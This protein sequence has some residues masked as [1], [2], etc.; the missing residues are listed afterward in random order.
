MGGTA[1]ALSEKFISFFNSYFLHLFLPQGSITRADKNSE[2]TIDLVFASLPLKN[3]LE[4]CKVREDLHQ[5]SDHKPIISV[6]S[7][8]PHLCKCKSG[9]SWKKANKEAMAERAKEINSFPHNFSSIS[10]IDYSIDYLISRM[11][12]VIDQHDPMS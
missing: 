2:T 9:P 3:A 11:K 12:E 4:S 7:F 6:F 10:D 8:V 1:D 5:G